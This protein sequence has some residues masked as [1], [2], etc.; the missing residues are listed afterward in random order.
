MALNYNKVIIAGN[1]TRDPQLR[2]LANERA[3]A[4]FGLAVNRRY[5]GGDGEM[6]EETAF[7]DC[8]AWGRTAELVGQYLAKGRGALVE[9]RLRM[10]S[11]EDKQTGQKRSKLLVSADTVQFTDSAPRGEGGSRASGQ[12][13]RADGASAPSLPPS[14]AA[15]VDDE[16]PF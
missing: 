10:D 13:E 8:E 16:P 3:V 14:G 12:D 1:L 11:W 15:P 9:G 4:N 7:I 5:K 6:K 2:F